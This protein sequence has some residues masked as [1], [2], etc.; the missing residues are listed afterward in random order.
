MSQKVDFSGE[1]DF[2]EKTTRAMEEIL[3]QRIAEVATGFIGKKVRIHYEDGPDHRITIEKDE[4]ILKAVKPGDL[5]IRLQT[6]VHFSIRAIVSIEL[7][8]ENEQKD[9]MPLSEI[10]AAGHIAYGADLLDQ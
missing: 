1:R 5:V 2:I 4:G 3:K 7:L 9:G 8:D 6:D 10:N